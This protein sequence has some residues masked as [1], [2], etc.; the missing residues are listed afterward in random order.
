[1]KTN[2]V[3]SCVVAYSLGALVPLYAMCDPASG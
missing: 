1:M 3:L 2:L